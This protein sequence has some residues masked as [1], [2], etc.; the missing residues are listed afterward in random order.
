MLLMDLTM[1]Y[2]PVVLSDFPEPSPGELC[3]ILS[4]GT[5]EALQE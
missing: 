4:A 1:L 2:C 5:V 3:A